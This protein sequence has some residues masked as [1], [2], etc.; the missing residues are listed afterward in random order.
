MNHLP[1]LRERL[2]PRPMVC[3]LV[4]LGGSSPPPE[5]PPDSTVEIYHS[6]HDFNYETKY[7]KSYKQYP[8]EARYNKPRDNRYLPQQSDSYVQQHYYQSP[9]Y[10]NIEEQN[11]SPLLQ[12]TMTAYQKQNSLDLSSLSLGT[13]YWEHDI[14]N[15]LET[16][17]SDSSPEFYNVNTQSHSSNDT[18]YLQDNFSKLGKSSPSLDQGYHTLVSP[19]PG[20]TT[21]N[22]WNGENIY[23]DRKILSKNNSFDRL[24]DELVFKIFSFLKSVDLSICARVCRRFNNLVWNPSLWKCIQLEGENISGDRAIRG[25]LRQLCGQGR[26]GACPSVERI[27]VTEGAVITDR[28]L[29]LLARRCPE[30][31]HLEVHGSVT[32]TSGAMY[33]IIT[34]CPNIQHIDVTGTLLIIVINSIIIP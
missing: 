16:S 20:S 32:I 25:V 22:L 13:S 18:K 8:L 9:S 1:G 10:F 11:D 27:Q 24:S 28:G 6:E 3:P 23:K 19:S 7:M 12:S 29:L 30:L 2:S 26:T 14:Y 21:P 31:I 5:H 15:K 33:E 17:Q 4:R 34:R